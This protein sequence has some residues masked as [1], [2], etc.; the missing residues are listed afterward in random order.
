[1]CFRKSESRKFPASLQVTV[2]NVLG[3]ILSNLNR[4]NRLNAMLYILKYNSKKWNAIETSLDV[5]RREIVDNITYN[6]KLW[7][8]LPHRRYNLL[9]RIQKLQ[10]FYLALYRIKSDSDFSDLKRLMGSVL[11]VWT[12][13]ES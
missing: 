5:L 1:M 8:K 4:P 11:K 10:N 9:R 13:D 7:R 12:N 6:L 2:P 3:F